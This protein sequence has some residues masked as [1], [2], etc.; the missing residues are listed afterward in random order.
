MRARCKERAISDQINPLARHKT[1]LA[2]SMI[3]TVGLLTACSA[4]KQ[5]GGARADTKAGGPQSISVST[6]TVVERS[7]RRSLDVVGSLEAQDDVTVSSQSSGNLEEILVDVGTPIRKG[8]VIGRI[9]QRELKLKAAQ[10]EATLRQAEAR[11]GITR[12]ERIDPQ[13]QPDVRQAFSA[14][15]RARN[16]L[17]A[18]QT[19]VNSGNISKQHYDI[20]Q[21]TFEQAEARYQAAM[22]NVRNLEAILE[23]KRAALA[24]S[25]EHLGDAAVLSPITGVVK[26]KLASKGEYLQ[27]GTPIATIVQINPL[28]L[29]LE[30]PEMVAARITKG[31]VVTLKVDTFPDR[32][33]KGRIARINPSVDEKNRS[34]IAEA[35]VPNDNALLK[36]GMFARARIAS[37]VEVATLMVPDKAVVSLAGVDKVFVVEG[38][39]AVERQVKLGT[40]DGSLIEVIDGVKAGD[41]VITSNTDQLHNGKAVSAT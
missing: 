23:E 14:M 40:R 11:L 36:P 28:R 12:G 24:I 33:F 8:Q 34:L 3:L 2:L 27:P 30:I 37:E 29:R 10:A 9:D 31:Q 5:E 6:T 21:K 7:A 38:D 26:Q 16:D 22:E 35:E 13:K 32:E 25:Q 15:E 20:A 18:A 39:Q 41:R 4:K 19:L 1:I 17:T